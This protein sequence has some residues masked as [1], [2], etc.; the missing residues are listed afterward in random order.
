MN[1][2]PTLQ[3]D[4]GNRLFFLPRSAITHYRM[5]ALDKKFDFIRFDIILE[6]ASK[7]ENEFLHAYLGGDHGNGNGC[8]HR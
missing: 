5:Y 1:C 7:A 3:D 4:R 8:H 6:I 2:F